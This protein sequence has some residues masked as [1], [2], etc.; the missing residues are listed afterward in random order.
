MTGVRFCGNDRGVG[1]VLMW[2]RATHG[3]ADWL[4]VLTGGFGVEPDSIFAMVCNAKLAF[5]EG[6]LLLTG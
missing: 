1:Q 4:T 3:Q 2:L 6:V 5:F